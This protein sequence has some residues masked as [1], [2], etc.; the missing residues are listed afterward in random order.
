MVVFR[1]GGRHRADRRVAPSHGSQRYDSGDPS[2]PSSNAYPDMIHDT[3][4]AGWLSQ[5]QRL[6]QYPSWACGGLGPAG[7]LWGG[8]ETNRELQVQFAAARAGVPTNSVYTSRILKD[9]S[10]E[11]MWLEHPV[12]EDGVLYLLSFD[13]VRASPALSLLVQSRS[14]VALD[15]V[16]VCSDKWSTESLVTPSVFNM[17]LTAPLEFKEPGEGVQCRSP[18]RL[19]IVAAAEVLSPARRRG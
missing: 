9:C 3:R 11:A 7:R 8:P 16:V 6:W 18:T 4:F 13:A 17:G 14:C 2:Y 15:W 19:A 1:T 5:H 12:L 10:A